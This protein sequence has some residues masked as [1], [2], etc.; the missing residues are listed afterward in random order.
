MSKFI[1]SKSGGARINNP[2]KT[3]AMAETKTAAAPTSLPIFA[4]GCLFGLARSTTASIAVLI[5]SAMNTN[6][7][8]KISIAHSVNEISNQIPTTNT[9][10]V[11]AVCIHALRWVLRT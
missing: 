11:I 8:V 3:E 1:F 7:I 9:A 6:A 2:T 10:K 5:N 4:S